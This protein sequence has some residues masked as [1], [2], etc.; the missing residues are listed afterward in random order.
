MKKKH[1]FFSALLLFFSSNNFAANNTAITTTNLNLRLQDN[2]N[3]KI[4]DVINKGDTI[5]IIK[6]IDNWSQIKHKETIGFV[7][8]E[9]LKEIE[10]HKSSKI[11]TFKDQKGFLAGF[12]F[13]FFKFFVLTF[14]LFGT[15]KTYQLR[16]KD[17]RFKKGYREGNLSGGNLFR[18]ILICLIISF[19]AATIGGIISI[20]H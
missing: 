13:L 5:E 4:L 3:S 9:Y 18:V 19:F 10:I 15:F 12:K 16:K 11:E 6:Q 8:S 17:A 2:S 14:L 1:Y 7:S 20:F